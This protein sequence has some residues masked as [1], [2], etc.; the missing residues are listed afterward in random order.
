MGNDKSIFPFDSLK[1]KSYVTSASILGLV[2]WLA[3]LSNISGLGR[4]TT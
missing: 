2:L 1:G 4:L 3:L